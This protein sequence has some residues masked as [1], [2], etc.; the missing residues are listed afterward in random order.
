MTA[1]SI[2]TLGQIENP[3]TDTT[4]GAL[5]GFGLGSLAGGAGGVIGSIVGAAANSGALPKVGGTVG[6]VGELIK[7]GVN[8]LLNPPSASLQSPSSI[9]STP[10][11]AQASTSSL[12]AQLA[13]ES[14]A[15]K[16]ATLLTGGAGLLDEP[17]TTSRVLL[18]S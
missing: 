11:L 8:S 13:N 17:T 1:P 10:S 2:P 12:Q 16:T 3:S 15:A 7:S 5:L 4:G 18:G 14:V 6:Q 9:S